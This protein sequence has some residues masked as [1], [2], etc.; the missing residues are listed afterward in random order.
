MADIF[1]TRQQ[2]LHRPSRSRRNAMS[3]EE[4]HELKQKVAVTLKAAGPFVIGQPAAPG[5]EELRRIILQDTSAFVAKNFLTLL[6]SAESWNIHF[7]DWVNK[8]E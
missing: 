8:I 2:G 3:Q 7:S 5:E 6:A 4:I 1:E